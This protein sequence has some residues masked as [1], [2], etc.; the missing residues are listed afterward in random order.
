MQIKTEQ[1]GTDLY[2]LWDVLKVNVP[3]FIGSLPNPVT[4]S[5]RTTIV[6]SHNPQN[7]EVKQLDFLL[8]IGKQLRLNQ[9]FKTQLFN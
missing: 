3:M 2:K 1:S 6:I 8:N 4:S 5:K 9:K 7:S